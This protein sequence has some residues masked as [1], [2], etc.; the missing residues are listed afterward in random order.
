MPT[1]IC[2]QVMKPSSQSTGAVEAMAPALP[3]ASM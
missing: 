2:D 1:N 3:T